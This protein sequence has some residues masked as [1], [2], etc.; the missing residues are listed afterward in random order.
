MREPDTAQV[1]KS[2]DAMATHYDRQ[3]GRFERFVLGDARRWAVDKASGRVVEI[4]V[5][6]GLNLPLY[7]K[8]VDYVIG[9]DISNAMLERARIKVA[10]GVNIS[11][12]LRHGDAQELDL[13]DECVD[14]LVST[15]S[16]CTIPDPGRAAAEAFRVLVPGGRFVLAEHGPST[17]VVARAVMK[18]VE[19]L[20]VRFGADHLTRDPV[21]YL[22]D[23]GFLI[24]EVRRSG[25]GGV[26]FRVVARKPDPEWTA[27]GH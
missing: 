9:V 20:F 18:I 10:E 21:G 22:E 4:A 13:P 12:D 17:N 19:P 26:V 15:Y 11:V 14:T 5:G 25:R 8:D 6:T 2:F 16:F 23:E 7:G 1:A 3:I 24:D 27:L